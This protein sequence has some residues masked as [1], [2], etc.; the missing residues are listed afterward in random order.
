MTKANILIV[1]DDGI[2]AACLQAMVGRMGYAVAGTLASGEEAVAFMAGKQIDLVLMDIELAGPMNG[3]E[4]AGVIC[5]STDVPIV[6]LTGYSHD[7]LLEQAKIAA[8]YGYLIKPVPERELAATL[9]MAL[10]RH[11]LD[12]QLRQSQL[13]LAESELRYRTLANSGQA[14]IWT[15]GPDKLCNYFNEPWLRFTGRTLEQEVGNGWTEGVHPEDFDRCLQTYVTAFDKRDKFS[16]AYRLRNADGEYRWLQDDGTPRFDSTGNFLGYIGHC[17]DIS[18]LKK[19]E[20]ALQESEAQYRRIVQTAQESIW[21][22][23]ALMRTT[24]VN[25]HL[26]AMLGYAPEEMLG[27]PIDDFIYQ[28]DLHDHH[29]QV[30]LRQHGNNGRYERRLW[31]K[32]GRIVWTQ[33]SATAVQDSAGRFAGSFCMFT[34]IT[35]RKRAEEE[36]KRL[37]TQLIHAQKMEAIGTLAGGIAHDFNNI[38][39]AVLG[40]A[41]MA[42]DDTPHDSAVARDLNKVLEAGNRAAALVKQILAFSRQSASERV[43]LDPARTVKEVAQL[44]RPSLPS[45]IAIS[46]HIAATRPILADPTQLHQV[47]M[48]LCTNAFHAM[49]Q[50]GGALEIAL[51]DRELTAADLGQQP[52]IQPG[53]YVALSVSDTGPGIAPEIRERI[54]EPYFTTKG[55]GQGTG[56]GLSI[57]HGIVAEHGGFI[58]CESEPGRGAT[59]R[60]FLPA[61]NGDILLADTTAEPVPTGRERVLLVDDEEIL[62]EMGQAMLERL[63]YEVTVR[64]G[65][66]EALATFQNEPH[67]FDVVITD[68]TMPGMTGLDLARRMLQIRPDLPIILC[69]GYSNLVTA[70]QATRYGIKGF[71]MKPLA[72]KELATLLRTVLDGADP[73][74]GSTPP[75]D[76]GEAR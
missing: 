52:G 64:T 2:L 7:P 28:D 19:A 72:K 62:T 18:E 63:G 4:T 29:L 51:G 42:R 59:F 16:M 44:L 14:L 37:Q 54:F 76:G 48:N 3:I 45:T 71:A 36:R 17:L 67:R 46:Q 15:S 9:A 41:E 8:P 38:L 20:A 58:T 65:S 34:E 32:E 12:R 33:V 69:T 53:D 35:E 68:Q 1:E 6:F 39:G 61:I 40:Y 25:P 55:V 74:C 27:R 75:N 21:G 47:L 70:E 24:F 5:R 50:T 30:Q 57:V 66:L 60:V 31:H 23:D 13:A 10:H 49:E 11:A 26:T 56:L 43:A 22:M 73:P